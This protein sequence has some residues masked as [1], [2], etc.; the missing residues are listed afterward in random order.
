MS[1]KDIFHPAVRSA[2]LIDQTTSEQLTQY[3]HCICQVLQ[4]YA[5]T[6]PANGD[7]EVQL[8]TDTIHDHHQVIDIGW[9][10]HQ[11]IYNCLIHLDIKQGKVWI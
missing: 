1:A 7:I 4:D 11:R 8:V 10:G 3:R 9:V 5:Q 2:L 6:Q